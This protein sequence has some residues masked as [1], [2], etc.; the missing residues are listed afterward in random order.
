MSN[1]F[2]VDFI[3]KNFNLFMFNVKPIVIT[4]KKQ[5]KHEINQL[6]RIQ[7]RNY[8][9]SKNDNKINGHVVGGKNQYDQY[10]VK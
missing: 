5:Q 2:N 3:L 4:F 8:S 1:S 10:F 7:I 6:E 9:G